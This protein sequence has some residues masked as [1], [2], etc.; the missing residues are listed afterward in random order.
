MTTI[1]F[2]ITDSGGA[3]KFT[4]SRAGYYLHSVFTTRPWDR[5]SACDRLLHTRWVPVSACHLDSEHRIPR[6]F[7]V[8][9]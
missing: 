3:D 6:P 1:V 4:V 7:R 9:N 8:R 5:A 2:I